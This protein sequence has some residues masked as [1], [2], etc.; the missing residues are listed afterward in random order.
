MPCVGFKVQWNNKPL[1]EVIFSREE[2]GLSSTGLSYMESSTAL[3]LGIPYDETWFSI[4][5]KSREYIMATRIARD[6]LKSLHE[7]NAMR[8]SRLHV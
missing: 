8:S 2:E 3:E 4:P 6:W 5:L 7:E 1:Y